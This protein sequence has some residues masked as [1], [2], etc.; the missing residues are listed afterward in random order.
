MST[1]HAVSVSYDG[2]QLYVASDGGV[3]TFARA[4]DGSISKTASH[5]SAASYS[6]SLSP[7]GYALY[8]A[9]PGSSNSGGTKM[10]DRNSGGALS[11]NSYIGGCS[12]VNTAV[13]PDGLSVY[14]A[15]SCI[16]NAGGTYSFSRGLTSSGLTSVNGVS[17]APIDALV[18][19]PDGKNIYSGIY[20]STGTGGILVYS[21]SRNLGLGVFY[22]ARAWMPSATTI[23]YR[24][25]ATNSVGTGY[26]PDSTFTTL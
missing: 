9:F 4:G 20:P 24:G 13:S 23:Y 1:V 19:S 6:A 16:N 12:K 2:K 10:Y 26:S 5:S 18:A 22:Q 11:Y 14:S 17:S 7:D 21:R 8:S 3:S 25:F 15:A